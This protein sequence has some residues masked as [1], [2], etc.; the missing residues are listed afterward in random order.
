MKVLLLVAIL[1]AGCDGS[2]SVCNEYRLQQSIIDECSKRPD[3]RLTVADLY[4]LA[5]WKS[6]CDG[7][8][9]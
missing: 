3:C 5:Q 2:P 8:K 7:R 6:R 4:T 9:F 1:L